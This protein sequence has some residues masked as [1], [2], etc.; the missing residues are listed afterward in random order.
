MDR[1]QSQSIPAVDLGFLAQD[2]T[3]DEI[4]GPNS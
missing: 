2:R 3:M 1:I 4:S